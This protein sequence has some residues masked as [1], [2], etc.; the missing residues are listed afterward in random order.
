VESAIPGHPH[1]AI[2]GAAM[3]YLS[4]PGPAGRLRLYHEV[5]VVPDGEAYVEYVDCRPGTGLLGAL[6]G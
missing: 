2:F 6:P 5:S 4:T 1:I 3:R